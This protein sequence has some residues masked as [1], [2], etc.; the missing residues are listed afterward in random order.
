MS[1]DVRLLQLFRVK[2]TEGHIQELQFCLAS[3]MVARD[4]MNAHDA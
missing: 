2:D 3:M 4:G 1:P